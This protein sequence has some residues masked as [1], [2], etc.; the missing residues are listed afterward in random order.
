MCLKLDSLPVTQAKHQPFWDG[1]V[2]DR[3]MCL[4]V[5]IVSDDLPNSRKAVHADL[6]PY[7]DF[8]NFMEFLCP[9]SVTSGITVDDFS[10]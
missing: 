10:I 9:P 4:L 6:V 3:V 7:E 8:Y 2:N 1:I 5:K